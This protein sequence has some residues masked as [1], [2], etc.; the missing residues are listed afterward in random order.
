[1][2]NF[3]SKIEKNDTIIIFLKPGGKHTYRLL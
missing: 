1:M 3:H 2:N